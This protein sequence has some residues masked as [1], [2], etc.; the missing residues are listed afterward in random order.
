MS[1]DVPRHY[2]VKDTLK[3]SKIQ[4]SK[5][6]VVTNSPD[7]FRLTYME[8]SLGNETGNSVVMLSFACHSPIISHEASFQ[9]MGGRQPS[10]WVWQPYPSLKK[11]LI[12]RTTNGRT[13][14]V[15][16]RILLSPHPFRWLQCNQYPIQYYKGRKGG[17][18]T[19]PHQKFHKCTSDNAENAPSQAYTGILEEPFG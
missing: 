16:S 15:R 17:L 5:G 1:G 18:E 12:G 4:L 8:C 13:S 3:H 10:G 11:M 7:I 9:R 14:G 19:C 6:L 2:S